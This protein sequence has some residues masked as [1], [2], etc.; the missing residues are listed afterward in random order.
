MPK[1]DIHLPN[2][3]GSID[4]RL[5]NAKVRQLA[6]DRRQT[7]PYDWKPSASWTKLTK[8]EQRTRSESKRELRGKR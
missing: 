1:G 8:A 7:I 2:E 4:P 3:S 6:M 5:P